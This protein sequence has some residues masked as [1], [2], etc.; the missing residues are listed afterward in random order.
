MK[1]A[2]NNNNMKDLN[3]MGLVALDAT[4]LQEV[5]GGFTP[6]WLPAIVIRIVQEVIV[7]TMVKKVKESQ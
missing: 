4:Q 6:F 3:Q 7:D 1:N 5:K 2:N